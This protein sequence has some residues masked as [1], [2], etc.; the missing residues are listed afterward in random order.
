MRRVRGH[1]EVMVM[2]SRTSRI[3]WMWII[4]AIVV[5]IVVTLVLTS[6]GGGGGGGGGGVPGY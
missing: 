4:A 2:A 6:G 3:A 1:T 5:A